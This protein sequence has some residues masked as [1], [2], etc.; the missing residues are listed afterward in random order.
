MSLEISG[1]IGRAFRLRAGWFKPADVEPDDPN[2]PKHGY[3][4]VVHLLIPG[5]TDVSGHLH[6]ASLHREWKTKDV[7]PIDATFKEWEID[8]PSTGTFKVSGFFDADMD[9]YLESIEQEI[10]G[11]TYAPAGEG[12]GYVRYT[13]DAGLTEYSITNTS[14]DAVRLDATFELTASPT[15]E[16]IA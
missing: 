5:D 7:T 12:T 3:T 15:R 11:F 9:T 14:N 16:V 10:A 8:G 1:R 6:D 4:A 13:S 2:G